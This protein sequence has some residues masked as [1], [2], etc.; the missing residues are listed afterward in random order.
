M[1]NPHRILLVD[2]HPVFREGLC[3]I[4]HTHP[5]FQVAA[6]ASC[7]REGLEK[8][9]ICRPDLVLTDLRLGLESGQDLIRQILAIQPDMPILAVS[10][11]TETQQVLQTIEAGAK[12]YITKGASREEVLSAL[13]EVVQGRSYLHPEVAHVLFEKVRQP[14]CPTS[15]DKFELTARERDTLEGL[16]RGL[17]PHEVG[18]H[19]CLSVSTVKTY[20]RSLYR[21]L[22]VVNRTQLVLKAL[23]LELLSKPNLPVLAG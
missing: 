18:Q 19:L 7:V 23:E 14:L 22:E 9:S 8:F 12:G 20:M 16:C 2:D 5:N 21:K 3:S 1:S 15:P 4:I 17:T 11:L 6:E 10:M 13:Q